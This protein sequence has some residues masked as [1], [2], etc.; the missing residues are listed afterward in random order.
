[1]VGK[2]ELEKHRTYYDQE[3]EQSAYLKRRLTE[4]IKA[5][6]TVSSLS[7]THKLGQTKIY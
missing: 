6:K 3:Y 7:D 2:F 5:N 4:C 1:M